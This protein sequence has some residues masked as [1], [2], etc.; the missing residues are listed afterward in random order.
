MEA[1]Q[2]DHSWQFA[3]WLIQSNAGSKKSRCKEGFSTSRVRCSSPMM[4]RCTNYIMT[5][6]KSG[7]EEADWDRPQITLKYLILTGLHR[8]TQNLYF[9]G[10]VTS[11]TWEKSDNMLAQL[12]PC[13]GLDGRWRNASW[14]KWGHV[15]KITVD[16]GRHERSSFSARSSISPSRHVS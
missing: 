9:R 4:R 7:N 16:G 5:G 11:E 13:D 3:T 15:R 1:E 6:S 12:S 14:S 2:C 8:L 10:H